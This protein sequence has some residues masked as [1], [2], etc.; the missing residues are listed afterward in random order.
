MF[1]LYPST[2]LKGK[3][4]AA[5]GQQAWR[6]AGRWGDEQQARGGGKARGPECAE[7]ALARDPGR[8]VRT[9]V[10]QPTELMVPPGRTRSYAERRAEGEP[11]TSSTASAP[12]PPVAALPHA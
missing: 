6:E 11:T 5:A 2:G 4:G 10:W 8:A 3:A 12:R 9:P 1:L 7:Q